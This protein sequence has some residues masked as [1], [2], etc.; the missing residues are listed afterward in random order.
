[1]IAVK[2][3]HIVLI[4]FVVLLSNTSLKAEFDILQDPVKKFSDRLWQLQFHSRKKSQWDQKSWF[5][6]EDLAV[7]EC[8][9]LNSEILAP[10]ELETEQNN[11]VLRIT[12]AVRLYALKWA[13][14]VSSF[15]TS[16]AKGTFLSHASA[17]RCSCSY[18]SAIVKQKGRYHMKWT[19]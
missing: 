19:S 12:L 3:N 16:F 8:Q 5:H 10:L 7:K 4:S 2:I 11:D 9:L 1:M 17:V 14:I 18:R 13:K 6:H 15:F